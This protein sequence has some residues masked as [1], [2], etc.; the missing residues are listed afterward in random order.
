MGVRECLKARPDRDKREQPIADCGESHPERSH[1]CRGIGRFP[2]GRYGRDR[3]SCF[4]LKINH[5]SD[6]SATNV[7]SHQYFSILE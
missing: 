6:L 2:T 4:H 7:Q 3:H 5:L 1:T